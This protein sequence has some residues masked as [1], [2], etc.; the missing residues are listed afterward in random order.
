LSSRVGEN[1]AMKAKRALTRSNIHQVEVEGDEL[2]FYVNSNRFSRMLKALVD[3]SVDVYL[4][5]R[6]TGEPLAPLT[7]PKPPAE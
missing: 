1:Q 7:G 2:R 3:G 5:E 4:L 6:F